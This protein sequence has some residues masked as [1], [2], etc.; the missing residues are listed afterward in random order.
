MSKAGNIC[1][2]G[3]FRGSKSSQCQFHT[4][5]AY[6]HTPTAVN[7][8]KLPVCPSL[9]AIAAPLTHSSIASYLSSPRRSNRVPGLNLGLGRVVG[10]VGAAREGAVGDMALGSPGAG[11]GGGHERVLVR[12]RVDGVR[13]PG[14]PEGFD[15]AAVE[16]GLLVLALVGFIIGEWCLA[17]CRGGSMCLDEWKKEG[18]GG[19]VRVVIVL[20]VVNPSGSD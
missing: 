11:V 18:A 16:G 2:T 14:V 12:R 9:L 7:R 8:L 19:Y 1:T 20:G 17:R 6:I 13:D 10:L 15:V 5:N 4:L 3:T